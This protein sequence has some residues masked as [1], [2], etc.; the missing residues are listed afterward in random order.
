[1]ADDQEREEL[2]AGASKGRLINFSVPGVP[3]VAFRPSDLLKELGVRLTRRERS[4]GAIAKRDLTRYYK[5]LGSTLAALDLREDEAGL[6]TEAAAGLRD[7][8]EPARSVVHRYL[9]A[10][11]ADTIRAGGLGAKWQVSD[12]DALVERIRSLSPVE[13]TALL[14]ALERYWDAPDSMPRGELLRRVGLVD[15]AR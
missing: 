4:P 6:L 10:E 7:I 9:W 3:Q 14:D 2:D 8:D 11:V 1:M 15:D 13:Q 5:L 12:T